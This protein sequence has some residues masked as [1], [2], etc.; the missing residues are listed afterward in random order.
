MITGINNILL[1]ATTIITSSYH[2]KELNHNTLSNNFANTVILLAKSGTMTSKIDNFG[3]ILIPKVLRKTIG[4]E[5]GEEIELHVDEKTLSLN[6]KPKTDDQPYESKIYYNDWGLPQIVT[7]G[8]FP[9][10]FDTV[11]AI[12]DAREEYL[13]RKFGGE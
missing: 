8:K 13:D 3:R 6:I 9:D 4:L 1:A 11:K 7:S 5:L 10:D 12:K 2:A